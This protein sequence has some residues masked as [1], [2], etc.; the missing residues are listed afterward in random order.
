MN[1][2][3]GGK[4]RKQCDTMIPLNNPDHSVHGKVQKMTNEDGTPKGLRSVLME[5]GFDVRQL[6]AKCSPVC[7]FKSENCCMARLLSQQN[8]F[9]N[10]EKSQCLRLSSRRQVTY[11]SFYR[12]ST[13]S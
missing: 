12:N 3:D 4:R 2:S 5:R 8:D 9:T 6:K 13:V 11:V 7:P 10:Q 1:K